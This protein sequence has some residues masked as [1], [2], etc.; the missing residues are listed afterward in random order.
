MFSISMDPFFTRGPQAD[1]VE[2]IA[3]SEGF[4]GKPQKNVFPECWY[5]ACF[6]H[7][8][9]FHWPAEDNLA[10][11]AGTASKVLPPAACWKFRRSPNSRQRANSHFYQPRSSVEDNLAG[12]AGIAGNGR[13]PAAGNLPPGGRFD[14]SPAAPFFFLTKNWVDFDII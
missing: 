13:P 10:G 9:W 12:F 2:N 4:S 14:F 3:P 7:F 8:Y 11:E 5:V 6:S 1:A